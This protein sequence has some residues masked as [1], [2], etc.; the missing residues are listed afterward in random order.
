[1]D[2]IRRRL[3]MAGLSAA[4]GAAL[5]PPLPLSAATRPSGELEIDGRD[6]GLIA[7]APDD[8]SAAM[9]AAIDRAAAARLG[10]RLAAGRYRIGGVA[11]RPGSHLI[12]AGAATV[13]AFTSGPWCLGAREADDLAISDLSIDGGGSAQI[14]SDDVGL[15][16]LAGCGGVSLARLSVIGG[17][18]HGI[19]LDRVGGR[20]DAC[21]ITGCGRSGL[22]SL[23]ADGLAVTG[24]LVA[25]IANNG[26]QIWRREPGEDGTILSGNRI[27]RIAARDGGSGQNGNG[28]NV[29]RAGSVLVTGNR[30]ADCA[31]SAIRANAASNC[32]MTSNACARIGEVALYA[33]FGFEGVV[34]SGNLVDG[35]A[36]GI[37]VTNFNDG[38]RLAV[39]Q[40]NLVRNLSRREASEDRRGIG[41]SVEADAAVTGNVVEGAPTA[42][43]LAGWGNFRRDIAITG[44]VVRAS[45]VGIGISNGEGA[46]TTLVSQNV[47]AGVTAGGI[48]LM[49]GD[50][51]VG[52]DLA[53]AAGDA[54]AGMVITANAVSQGG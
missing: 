4:A 28:I 29:F 34:I 21:T 41:I 20:I 10:L 17:A 35:A 32:Q 27:L 16:D 26:I 5:A 25:D 6:A 1:M 14:G 51:P 44:N 7:D 52:T 18:R 11:L 3:L 53:N 39:V 54:P 12:G 13:L 8:Q 48:M 50:R 24:T 33:E 46:G 38:G 9:Q 47:L 40:G 36:Q 23:D 15:L 42:G 30:I 22:F 43:I 49:D 31:F 19:A 37:S 2:D 45:A